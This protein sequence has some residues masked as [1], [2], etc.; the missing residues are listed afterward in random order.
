MEI[1][2]IWRGEYTYDDT[3]KGYRPGG[4]IVPFILR[5][6]LATVTGKR[7]SFAGICQDDPAIVGVSDH[8]KVY[9]IISHDDLFLVKLYPKVFGYDQSGKL[10]TSD[11][12]HPEI[13]YNGIF[14]ENN[15]FHGQWRMEKTLRMIK[16]TVCEV[17]ASSGHWWMKRI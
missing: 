11:E 12:P 13:L 16:D 8:A 9:G 3:Y 7:G 2:G 15:V 17:S 10:L 6:K 5:I 1:D 4:G 14:S